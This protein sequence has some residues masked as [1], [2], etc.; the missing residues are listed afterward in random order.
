MNVKQIL[1]LDLLLDCCD[2]SII[3]ILYLF[4]LQQMD[5]SIEMADEIE[6]AG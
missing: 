5:N 4:Y 1:E 6:Y 2:S 3:P